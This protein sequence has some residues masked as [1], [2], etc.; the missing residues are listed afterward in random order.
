MATE[1]GTASKGMAYETS[2]TANAK[3]GTVAQNASTFFLDVKCFLEGVQVPHSTISV[4][5]G[6]TAPPTCTL[7]LPAHKVIRDL[8]ETTKIHVFFKDFLPT[9]AGVYEWRLLFDGELSSFSYSI[10]ADGAYMQINGIHSAA[11]M[12][13]MQLMSLDVSEFISN[14]IG[15]AVGQATLTTLLSQSQ[16]TSTLISQI[17]E[18]STYKNMA[19]IVFQLM[20]TILKGTGNS[21]TGQYYN[22]KLGDV[23]GSWK[24]LKRIYGVSVEAKDADTVTYADN[25]KPSKVSVANGPRSASISYAE[26]LAKDEKSAPKSMFYTKSDFVKE[27]DIAARTEYR[28]MNESFLSKLDQVTLGMRHYLGYDSSDSDY[29]LPLNSGFRSEAYNDDEGGV[30]GS[31]HTTGEA[32][33]VRTD[34]WTEAQIDTLVKYARQ[35]GLWTQ[36]S[37]EAK[38]G[39]TIFYVHLGLGG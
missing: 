8:P 9:E 31:K 22:S 2:D 5:Y 39:N 7:L 11:Y 14:P 4:S 38:K 26:Y 13:L 20:R 12:H 32:V 16:V 19:D 21:A 29:K 1:K 34:G 33:D 6:V 23:A 36:T 37:R 35:A 28:G 15:T 10:S 18:K 27:R 17:I 30:V 3:V 24:I 25:Y